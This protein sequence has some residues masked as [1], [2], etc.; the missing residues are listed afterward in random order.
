MSYKFRE[1]QA[2]TQ[3]IFQAKAKAKNFLL[4]WAP[5]DRPS[6]PVPLRDQLPRHDAPHHG[7]L[8]PRSRLPTLPATIR[9][10]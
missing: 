10:G 6:A 9:Q 4:N 5:D 8:H 2:K 7:R 1:S 3:V